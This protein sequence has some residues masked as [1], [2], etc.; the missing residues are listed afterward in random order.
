[1]PKDLC[2]CN[3]C[4]G[5][6]CGCIDG[7]MWDGCHIGCVQSFCC[8]SMTCIIGAPSDCKF[9]FIP[10]TISAPCFVK[11]FPCGGLGCGLGPKS[12]M[13]CAHT[14]FCGI[15]FVNAVFG[16][17]CFKPARSPQV[18]SILGV[19]LYGE[20]PPKCRVELCARYSSPTIGNRRISP[21]CPGIEEEGAPPG[22]V[23]MAR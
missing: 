2:V 19:K 6:G 21:D 10:S 1:M 17:D 12:A 15:F 5:P 13:L 4:C 20:E 16:D 14:S 11:G 3:A 22:P 18:C 7:F 9:F 23:E 8:I